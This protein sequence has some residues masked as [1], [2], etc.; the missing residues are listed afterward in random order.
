MTT[1]DTVPADV[2]E[3]IVE[4]DAFIA[5]EVRPLEAEGDN[6]R[7]FDH[8]REYA[9]TDFD[10]GGIPLAVSWCSTRK[11]RCCTSTS[12]TATARKKSRFGETRFDTVRQPTAL[13]HS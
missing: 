13:P 6:A 8:R 3:L 4:I 9:R 1:A 5:A 2:G 12:S 10:A 11:L 7:F